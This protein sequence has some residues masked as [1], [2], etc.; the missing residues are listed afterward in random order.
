MNKFQRTDALSR[1]VGKYV[2][3]KSSVQ[4]DQGKDQHIPVMEGVAYVDRFV[5]DPATGESSCIIAVVPS[6]PD[7]QP[8]LVRVEQKLL[9]NPKE[10]G[11]ILGARGVIVLNLTHASKYLLASAVEAIKLGKSRELVKKPGW[12]AVHRA[13]FTGSKLITSSGIDADAFWLESLDAPVMGAR[14][15]LH[16]WQAKI[17]VHI[18]AN[19]IVLAM[20][21][22]G[23]AS[24]FLD[25]LKL[26]SFL[27]NFFGEKGT[28][29]TLAEQCAASILGNG[30]DPAQGAHEDHP[31]Y[32]S[33]FNGTVN[34]CEKYLSRYSP[35]PILFDELTEV[36]TSVIN[37]L[38]YMI[39]SGEGK[40]RMLPNGE[41]A[42]RERWQS[43]VITSAEV[44]IV[45]R[46]TES[47]K[48]MLGGQ[49]DRAIDI[50][51]TESR[52]LTHYGSFDS[53]NAVA[54]HLKHS[55]GEVYGSAGEAIIQYCC[56][57]PD[58]VN[59]LVKQAP[60]IERRLLP[61]GCGDGE[62]RVVQRLAGAVVAGRIAVM[63]G[64]FEEKAIEKIDAAFELVTGLWWGARGGALAHVR[65]FLEEHIEEIQYGEPDPDCE[66]IA[67]VDDQ[68]TVIPTNVFARAFGE[69]AQRMLGEL[70][71]LGIL[72][73]QQEGRHM[74][75]F[76]NGRV[77]GYKLV[78]K[79]VWTGEDQLVK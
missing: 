75:R 32:V 23:M 29:K 70:K 69:D 73:C 37:A 40:I 66:A 77:L 20:V 7:M 39:A 79:R 54:R 36:S 16:T 51:I 43:N 13:F 34:G 31:A 12:V 11:A 3:Q 56:D 59:D 46:I 8:S 61:K 10:L 26:S 45:E 47:G 19:P 71:G 52:V 33:R 38:C 63:A 42:P 6:V 72:K 68:Y 30:V 48:Q 64:V 57:N 21:C 49:A 67:F 41:K 14:G 2:C 4:F 55:C 78:S 9:S 18:V 25:R 65:S 22:I 60:D 76:R 74:Y 28:G 5:K 17:G 15:E 58:V 62:R 35:L 53:F 50:P 1:M 27:A 24:L 44:S